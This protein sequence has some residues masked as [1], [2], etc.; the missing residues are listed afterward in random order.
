MILTKEKKAYAEGIFDRLEENGFVGRRARVDFFP[1]DL[2]ERVT[3][4]NFNNLGSWNGQRIGD[5]F[6]RNINMD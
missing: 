3:R 5:H 6:Y 4:R 2:F 1:S